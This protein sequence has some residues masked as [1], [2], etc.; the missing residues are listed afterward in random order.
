ML[1]NPYSMELEVIS[2]TPFVQN[3]CLT[4]YIG[5][6]VRSTDPRRR[7]AIQSFLLP[8]KGR[9]LGGLRAKVQDQKGF[10]SYCNQ[11]DL[12]VLLGLGTVGR[13]CYWLGQRYVGPGEEGWVGLYADEED[14]FDDLYEREMMVRYDYPSIPEGTSMTRHVH[15]EEGVDVEET[16]T[17]VIDACRFTGECPDPRW[18]TIRDRWSRVERIKATWD[19]L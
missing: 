6:E 5:V 12:E 2:A 7:W 1:L 13:T 4:E 19:L 14:L 11:R 15:I 18:E 9:A 10:V 17:L 8:P 3:A 16:W